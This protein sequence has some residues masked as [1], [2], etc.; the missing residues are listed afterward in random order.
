M[1]A[2]FAVLLV[3]LLASCSHAPKKETKR[4]AFVV[5]SAD[6]IPKA[7]KK[8]GAYLTEVT[9]P[10]H[11]L[12]H[13]GYIVDFISPKG[14]KTP[15]DGM[16]QADALSKKLLADKG[17]EKAL[18]SSKP[19]SSIDKA[20]YDAVFFAGGHG[21]MFDFPDNKDLQELTATVYE[22]GGVVGAVCHG[23]ASLVNV[24]L[25][26]GA[27]LVKDKKVTGFTNKEEEAVKLTQAMP[28]LLETKLKER[29]A[30]FSGAK[31]FQKNVVVSERLV[32]GQNPASASGVA[33]QMLKLIHPEKV[34]F[35]KK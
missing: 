33:A 24:K 35:K 8:T 16:D 5:T 19:A 15:L 23:P 25:K 3:S 10:Y 7:K 12:A 4:I 31:N 27:Y 34:P 22:K 1:R 30:T 26:N 21:T 17:F 13:T 11:V 32:T 6:M 2:L 9:H 14:G 29:G 18:N 28:F 20:S